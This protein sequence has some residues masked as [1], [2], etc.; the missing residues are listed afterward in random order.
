MNKLVCTAITVPSKSNGGYQT[1]GDG[2]GN[3]KMF[4]EKKGVVME[5]DE[6]DIIA[7]Q[8]CLKFFNPS[9][10]TA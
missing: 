8:D 7:L 1:L 2:E 9:I 10:I 5:L 6:T 3:K 4:L